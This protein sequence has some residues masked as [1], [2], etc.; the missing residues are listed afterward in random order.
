MKKYNDFMNESIEY[1]IFDILNSNIHDKINAF[2]SKIFFLKEGKLIQYGSFYFKNWDEDFIKLYN[3]MTNMVVKYDLY[4][5][6]ILKEDDD[7]IYGI[8]TLPKTEYSFLN[9]LTSHYTAFSLIVNYLNIKILESI[10]NNKPIASRQLNFKK[11][12]SNWEDELYNY[13]KLIKK[14]K[15]DI[16]LPG[17]KIFDDLFNIIIKTNKMGYDSEDKMVNILRNYNKNI[18]NI[19]TGGHGKK[20]DII[21]GVDITF[22]FKNKNYTIQ[23][24]KCEHVILE[25]NNYIVQGVSNIK[26]YKTDYLS[27]ED[28][29]KDIYMFRNRNIII[30][31]NLYIIPI[32]NL[33]KL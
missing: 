5:D 4:N 13:F 11:D 17:N 15:N 2:S 28:S 7:R 24:K 9:Y 33:V 8:H 31:N 3:K 12:K 27:F 6:Y 21:D 20:T 23:H 26:N 14:F 18:K 30:N 22:E 29:K 19:Q 16:F 32:Q 10:Y 1:S 25:H